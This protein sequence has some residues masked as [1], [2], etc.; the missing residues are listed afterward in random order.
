MQSDNF[1]CQ[2]FSCFRLRELYGIADLDFLTLFV[3][4]PQF[5]RLLPAAYHLERLRT[6][7]HFVIHTLIPYINQLLT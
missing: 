5:N 3:I 1:R 4:Q 7:I 2:L 6:K